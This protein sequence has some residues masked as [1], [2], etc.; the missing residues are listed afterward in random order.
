MTFRLL[1]ASLLSFLGE[2]AEAMAEVQAAPAKSGSRAVLTTAVAAAPGADGGGTRVPETLSGLP[3]GKCLI[4]NP[5]PDK[6]QAEDINHLL[7]LSTGAPTLRN[8]GLG[9]TAGGAA[10]AHRLSAWAETLFAKFEASRKSVLHRPAG[11]LQSLPFVVSG[12]RRA[13]AG[14]TVKFA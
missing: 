2:A 1:A 8:S 13:S 3:C 5:A 12:I 6:S 14:A 9:L 11:P 7:D 10:R 4:A